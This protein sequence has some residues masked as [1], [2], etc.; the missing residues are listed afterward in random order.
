MHPHYITVLTGCDSWEGALQMA[1]LLSE[2]QTE[3]GGEHL[4]GG[5]PA[6]GPGLLVLK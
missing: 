4:P 6:V 2:G 5:R 3:T 1:Q